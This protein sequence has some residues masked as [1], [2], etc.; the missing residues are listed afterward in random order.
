MN[1]DFFWMTPRQAKRK[2]FTHHG[3]IHGIPV[4]LGDV[5]SDAPFVKAKNLF[6]DLALD[7]AEILHE[8]L[9]RAGKVDQEFFAIAVGPE[10]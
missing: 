10:L 4:Y 7:L 3:L 9:A 8:F 6:C 1:L 5:D 2:G